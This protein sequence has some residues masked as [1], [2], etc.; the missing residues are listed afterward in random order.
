MKIENFHFL[1]DMLVGPNSQMAPK[2]PGVFSKEDVDVFKYAL[3][4]PGMSNIK[5]I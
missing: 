4:K 1:D 3:S 2:K 5:G